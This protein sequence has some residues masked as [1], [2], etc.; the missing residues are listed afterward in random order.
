MKHTLIKIGKTNSEV[1]DLIERNSEILESSN[2]VIR[3]YKTDISL[4]PRRVPHKIVG[5][6]KE[7]GFL[8]MTT[9][10]MNTMFYPVGKTWQTLFTHFYPKKF[11]GQIDFLGNIELQVAEIDYNFFFS[12]RP[13]GFKSESDANDSL[14]LVVDSLTVQSNSNEY[15]TSLVGDPFS[16]ND[17]LRT[18]F[19]HNKRR[20]E[21]YLSPK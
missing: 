10:T 7:N 11:V 17:V 13:V 21:R 4:N 9:E 18:E 12:K 8:Y 3:E 16:K 20:L 6:L 1:S 2:L 15:T 14:E 19:L 5:H